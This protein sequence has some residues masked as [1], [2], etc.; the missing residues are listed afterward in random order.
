MLAENFKMSKLVRHLET[1][2]VAANSIKVEMGN[3]S[4]NFPPNFRSRLTYLLMG[5]TSTG[6]GDGRI[7]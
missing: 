3:T 4:N 2:S 7:T 6:P 5:M 1:F